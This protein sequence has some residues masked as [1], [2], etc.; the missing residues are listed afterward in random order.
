MK[1]GRLNGRWAGEIEYK[2]DTPS[3]DYFFTLT[4]FKNLK[5]YVSLCHVMYEPGQYTIIVFKLKFTVFF[6]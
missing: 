1:I 2:P 3:T 5:K 4:Y 6:R